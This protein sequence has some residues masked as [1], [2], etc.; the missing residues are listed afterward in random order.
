MKKRRRKKEKKTIMCLGSCS[1][2]LA[3]GSP[4]LGHLPASL[5]PLVDLAQLHLPA[6]H[7]WQREKNLCS[8]VALLPGKFFP[9][10][11]VFQKNAQKIFAFQKTHSAKK[12][13]SKKILNI[14]GQSGRFPDSL[15]DLKRVWKISRQSK[16]LP[17]SLKNF[18]TV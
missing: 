12:A 5:L 11:K 17:D 6:L 3:P 8:R 10:R 18:W 14:S 16:R 1:L 13:S 4:L 7:C 2:C 15:E 9:V